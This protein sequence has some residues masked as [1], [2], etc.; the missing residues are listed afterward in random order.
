MHVAPPCA[1][2]PERAPDLRFPAALRL[3]R[4]RDIAYTFSAGRRV[5]GRYMTLIAAPAPAGEGFKTSVM[6]RKKEFRRAV[7]R[8]RAKRRLRETMRLQ[9]AACPAHTWLIIMARPGVGSAAWQ[10][11]A[12]DFAACSAQLK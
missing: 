3:H 7:A 8:N 5:Y 6:A 4:Q 11:L 10:E 2:E 9:R 12:A 1:D